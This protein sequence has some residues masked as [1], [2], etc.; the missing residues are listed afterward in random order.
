MGDVLLQIAGGLAVLVSVIHGVLGETKIFAKAKIEPAWIK[1]M[2]RLIWQCSTLA[3]ISCGVLLIVAPYVG[4]PAR[5]WIVGI[6]VVNFLA[7]A[8]G[9]AWAT[10]F[11]HI[12]WMAMVL[13]S[14][15]ALAGL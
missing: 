4:A 3:W 2:L 13:A 1:L 8:I 14:G 5:N 11:R 12:G 15:L 6:A 10:R 7:A 9:N